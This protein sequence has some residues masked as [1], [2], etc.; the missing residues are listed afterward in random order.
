MTWASETGASLGAGGA[1]K[2]SVGGP[3]GAVAG[4]RL[5][6]GGAAKVS[7]GAVAAVLVCGEGAPFGLG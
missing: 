2:V 3:G 6:A 5:G 7:G 1:A 4:A